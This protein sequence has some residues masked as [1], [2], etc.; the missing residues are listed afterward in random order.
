MELLNFKYYTLSINYNYRGLNNLISCD[1][2]I[3]HSYKEMTKDIDDFEI[4]WPPR[5]VVN[6]KVIFPNNKRP[7]VNVFYL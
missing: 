4:A 2:K 7:K 1:F 6:G 3:W 5:W